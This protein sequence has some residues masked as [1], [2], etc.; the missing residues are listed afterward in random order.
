MAFRITAAHEAP[1]VDFEIAIKGRQNP[2]LFSVPKMQYLPRDVADIYAEWF[3]EQVEKR[4]ATDRICNLKILELLL[5]EKTYAV[6]ERLTDGELAE[7][8]EHWE[9]E[10]KVKAG[11]SSASSVS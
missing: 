7:I 4:T 8:A 11:E 6:L 9:T 1:T 2:M 5:P 10:S 3:K